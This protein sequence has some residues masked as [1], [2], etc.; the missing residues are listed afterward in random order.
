MTITIIWS[1]VYT[2]IAV[3]CHKI[4]KKIA[5]GDNFICLV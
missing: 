5:E 4:E 3:K 2:I 1:I